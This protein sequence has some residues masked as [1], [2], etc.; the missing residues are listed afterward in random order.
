MKNK[1][2]LILLVMVLAISI[3]GAGCP[4]PSEEVIEISFAHFFPAVHPVHMRF[5]EWA[6]DI[7]DATDG[8]VH[9]TIHYAETLLKAPET[10]EGIVSGVAD[11]GIVVPAYTPGLFPLFELFDLP[12]GYNNNEVITKVLWDCYK[13]FDPEELSGVKVLQAY[14]IGPGGIAM[15]RDPIHSLEDLNGKQI[16]ATGL[17]ADLVAALGA[18]PVSI[19]MPEAYEALSRGVCDGAINIYDAFITWKL[20]E[21]TKYITMTPFLY[22]GI[23]LVVMD[24]DTWNS[25]PSDVQAVFEEISEDYIDYHAH[26]EAENAIKSIRALV[27]MQKEIIILSDEEEARWKE[28]VKPV[29]DNAIQ[30]REA[31]GIPAR[32]FWN[33]MLRLADKYNAVYPS[34]E[35]EYM[36]I[37]G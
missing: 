33:E 28:A 31:K 9:I 2:L 25:L 34:L 23:F 14:A 37:V 24:I 1:V 11:S 13:K 18:S 7:E 27:D 36:K 26:C 29:V 16:R 6:K 20:A 15:V 17:T 3:G 19:P 10:Y 5:V 12:V 4:Q 8:R 32:E 21:V 30:S 22:T 35:D